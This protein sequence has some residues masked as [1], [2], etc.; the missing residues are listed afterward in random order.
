[1]PESNAYQPIS[2]QQGAGMLGR[3]PVARDSF[4]TTMASSL[5]AIVKLQYTRSAQNK[6]IV[7][8]DIT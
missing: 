5:A 1:M 4:L 8:P 3:S 2:L 7:T 6:T